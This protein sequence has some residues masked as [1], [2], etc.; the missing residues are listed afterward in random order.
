MNAQSAS[1]PVAGD[2]RWDNIQRIDEGFSSLR[3]GNNDQA[4]QNSSRNN[5]NPYQ[6]E[7]A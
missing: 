4:L 5:K 6:P 1:Q 2:H 7:P 3:A